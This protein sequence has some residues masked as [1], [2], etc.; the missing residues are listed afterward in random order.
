MWPALFSLWLTLAVAAPRKPAQRR[1]PP[2]RRPLLEAL[3]DRSLPSTLTV[4]NTADN[5][6]GSLRAEIAAAQGGDTIVFDP[7]LEFQSINLTSGELTIKMSLTIQGTAAGFEAITSLGANRIFDITGN[8]SVALDN[9]L[10]GGG[11]VYSKTGGGGL[12]NTA[13]VTLNNCTFSANTVNNFSGSGG[14][15][16]N[17]GTVT[18][19]NCRFLENIADD[20]GGAIDNRGTLSISGS[21]LIGDSA[22]QGGEEVS[23]YGTLTVTGTTFQAAGDSVTEGGAIVNF[24]SATLD[25]CVLSGTASFGGAVFNAGTMTLTNT[26]IS[27]G[28]VALV[29]GGGI[30][31]TG[32]LTLS[33]CTVTGDSARTAGG[34]IYNVGT[35]SITNGSTVTGNSAPFGADVYNLG[36]LSISSDS[37]VGVIG[38]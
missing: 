33:D 2:S 15:I 36:T 26:T 24:G 12:Y 3:E 14:A 32:T 38:P 30:Y 8:A 6:P 5:G 4:T 19:T 11:A 10:I 17:L 21:S 16:E 1:R 34:G 23:N 35:L 18:V 7:S 37:T 28:G 25:N 20:E 9:L 22:G 31:N 13:T 27:G 29:D